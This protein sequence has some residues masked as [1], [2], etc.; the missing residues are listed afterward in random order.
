MSAVELDLD[1]ITARVEAATEGPWEW[2][3]DAPDL[4][5]PDPDPLFP[6]WPYTFVI[7]DCNGVASVG[8]ADREFIAHARTDI[9]L[10]LAEVERLRDEYQALHAEHLDSIEVFAR[11]LRRRVG[12]RDE[13]RAALAGMVPAEKVR[14]LADE[15]RALLPEA[16]S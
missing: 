5:A 16:T 14:E 11:T 12:E 9:P 8:P 10:L 13:A 2:E 6:D 4:I 3:D 15:I 7:T 1:A